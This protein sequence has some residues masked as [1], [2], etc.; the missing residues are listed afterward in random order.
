LDAFEDDRKPGDALQPGDVCPA[1]AGVDEAADGPGRAL[2]SVDLRVILV[3]E[4]RAEVLEPT[5]ED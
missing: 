5:E 1:Q 3:L 4:I 2:G